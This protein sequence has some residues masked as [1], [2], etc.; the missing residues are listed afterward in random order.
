MKRIHDGPLVGVWIQGE[1][2]LEYLPRAGEV[3]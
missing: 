3:L 1:G 2:K